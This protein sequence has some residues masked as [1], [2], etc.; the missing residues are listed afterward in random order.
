VE[1]NDWKD[2]FGPDGE[3]FERACQEETLPQEE[4]GDEVDQNEEEEESSDPIQL[5]E[6]LKSDGQAI[7]RDLWDEN[8][9]EQLSSAFD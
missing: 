1:K 2:G 8:H 6:D 9:D 5:R 7:Q 4:D 3:Y